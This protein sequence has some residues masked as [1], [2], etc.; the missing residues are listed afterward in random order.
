MINLIAN[1]VLEK[2]VYNILNPF[3][4]EKKLL[5]VKIVHSEGKNSKLELYLDKLDGKVSLEECA[6]INREVSSLLDIEEI[7]KGSYR[8][9]ISSPGI[10][11]SLT[12]LEDF[13][14]YKNFR[15]KVVKSN[16]ITNG[17]LVGY[18]SKSINLLNK[19]SLKNIDIS[20]IKDIKL[21]VDKL[22]FEKL[23]K[24]ESL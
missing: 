3:F 22:S 16:S 11:R 9:E 2:K 23:K 17:E 21:D 15:V 19:G 12:R 1:T 20:E 8:L 18:S 10:D 13:S 6:L 7:I 24:M 14:K 5:L 4:E